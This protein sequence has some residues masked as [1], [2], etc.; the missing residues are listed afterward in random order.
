MWLGTRMP[1]LTDAQKAAF[2]L[3]GHHLTDRLPADRLVSAVR[4]SGGIVSPGLVPVG[5]EEGE[6]VRVIAGEAGSR[7]V[8]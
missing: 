1:E 4:D 7:S 5:H 2:R 6:R 3:R 8:R